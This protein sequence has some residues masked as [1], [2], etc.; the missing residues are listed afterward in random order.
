MPTTTITPPTRMAT[1]GTSRPPKL[2]IESINL[3]TRHLL[4]ALRST[5]GRC[6]FRD[7]VRVN[8]L[9]DQ[10]LPLLLSHH[11]LDQ[12]P[13]DRCHQ[14]DDWDQQDPGTPEGTHQNEAFH[15]N[16]LPLLDFLVE[17][18]GIEPVASWLQTRRSPS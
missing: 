10:R 14:Q 15:S 6:F 1:I 3:F 11:R 16:K 8:P 17:L 7:R 2:A 9:I 12:L 5:Q 4:L 13:D 18:T